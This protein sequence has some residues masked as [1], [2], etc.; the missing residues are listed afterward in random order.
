[1]NVKA[2][3]LLEL[4]KN[5]LNAFTNDEFILHY[6]PYWDIKTKNIIGMEALI[7]WQSKDKG[8]IPPGRFI[9]VLED[10]GMIIEGGEWVLRAAIRQIKE[11]QDKGHPVVPVSV[12][13]SLIQFK[14]KGLAEMVDRVIREH[15]FYPS[16][17]TLEITESA[18]MQDVEFT[19]SVLKKFKDTGL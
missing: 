12:N 17:L 9:P 4:E 14:Q 6:Q 8:L 3:E 13:L 10:T 19:R 7:R 11:W 2:S 18:F 1:M 15:G 16:L 5:L